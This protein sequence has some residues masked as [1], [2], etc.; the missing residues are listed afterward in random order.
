MHDLKDCLIVLDTLGTRI[1]SGIIGIYACRFDLDRPGA[2]ALELQLHI[3]S[4]SNTVVGRTCDADT[5]EWWSSRPDYDEVFG[6]PGISLQEALAA[7]TRFYDGA[8]T[9]W[10]YG[11]TA[12]TG[13]LAHAYEQLNCRP[14]WPYWAVKDG[15]T[16]AD[17]SCW[18][19]RRHVEVTPRGDTTLDTLRKRRLALQVAYNS[20]VA[21]AQIESAA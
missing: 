4:S 8:E 13:I 17:I 2:P 20:I 12:D 18:L 3:P 21:H 14:P 6:R 10:L 11:G 15:R 1:T 16:M 5:L 9:L 19:N 7:L